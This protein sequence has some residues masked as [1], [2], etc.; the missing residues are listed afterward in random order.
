MVG[1]GGVGGEVG[2]AG[3]LGGDDEVD[4]CVGEGLED[5]WV[6]V[7]DFDLVDEC[8]LEDL[9]HVLRRRQVVPQSAV[10]HADAGDSLVIK[11]HEHEEED[12]YDSHQFGNKHGH[13]CCAL[14]L[15]PSLSLSLSVLSFW[16]LFFFFGRN[17]GA[18]LWYNV[19]MSIRIHI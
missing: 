16:S 17:F 3:V 4:A 6:G 7:V 8:G 19:S 10:V 15:S 13:G 2:D 5:V 1:G 12:E 14:T 18:L 9:R 11:A